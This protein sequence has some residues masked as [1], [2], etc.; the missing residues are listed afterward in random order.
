MKWCMNIVTGVKS[1]SLVEI[2]SQGLSATHV[3]ICKSAVYVHHEIKQLLTLDCCQDI[4][5]SSGTKPRFKKAVSGDVL[6]MYDMNS[7][8]PAASGLG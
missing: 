3:T 1:L 5:S 7:S 6:A 8:S 2:S 4:S